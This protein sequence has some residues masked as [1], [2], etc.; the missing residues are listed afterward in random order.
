[1]SDPRDLKKK[2]KK[3]SMMLKF[4]PNLFKTE[5]MSEKAVSSFF[6]AFSYLPDH[7]KTN[8]QCFKRSRNNPFKTHEMCEIAVKRFSYALSYI[9]DQY[10]RPNRCVK[11]F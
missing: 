4:V 8:Y 11:L 10:V 9:P 6:Y 7:H 3:D 5:E 1:M 2:K